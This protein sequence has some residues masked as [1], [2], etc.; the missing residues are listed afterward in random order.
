MQYKSAVGF[1]VPREVYNT[2]Q[3]PD[4]EEMLYLGHIRVLISVDV[5]TDWA[6]AIAISA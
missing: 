6:S 5:L 3:N 4:L 2:M 1:S